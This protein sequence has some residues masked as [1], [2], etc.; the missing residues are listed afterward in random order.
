VAVG[1]VEGLHELID[2]LLSV[3][4]DMT[5]CNQVQNPA[6][7]DCYC[8]SIKS[9]YDFRVGGNAHHAVFQTITHMCYPQ[10]I[11]RFLKHDFNFLNILILLLAVTYLVLIAKSMLA[12]LHH[13]LRV[14]SAYRSLYNLQTNH[15]L[16]DR[17][18]FSRGGM[19]AQAL[20]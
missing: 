1:N 6:H 12:S 14:R 3:Q 13:Y 17:C 11:L 8:W 18:V 10:S 19:G 20:G 2:R 9:R 7:N 4:L 16:V 15:P 5:L